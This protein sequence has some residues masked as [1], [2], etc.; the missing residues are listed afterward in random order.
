MT[1]SEEKELFSRL[2]GHL[3]EKWLDSEL[4]DAMKYLM[5]AT[6]PVALHRAQ[7]TALFIE[8]INKHI[9]AAKK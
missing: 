9:A 5:Q 1:P 2:G 6:D 7:G 4:V 8:K 3:F